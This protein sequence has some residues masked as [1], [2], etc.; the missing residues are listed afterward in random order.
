VGIQPFCLNTTSLQDPS[1][2][3]PLAPLTPPSSLYRRN[4][5]N[6]FIDMTVP[7]N[8]LFQNESGEIILIP[9]TPAEVFGERVLRPLID[10]VYSLISRFFSGWSKSISP[11]A[12]ELL[13]TADT[14]S[15]N[16]RTS[17]P[18]KSDR[19]S[20]KSF[21]LPPTVPS[22]FSLSKARLTKIFLAADQLLARYLQILPAAS[23]QPLEEKAVPTQS[24]DEVITFLKNIKTCQDYVLEMPDAERIQFML[25]YELQKACREFAK[26]L[27]EMQF[28][29]DD[30]ARRYEKMKENVRDNCL[31]TLRAR[32]FFKKEKELF[33]SGQNSVFSHPEGTQKAIA[34]ETSRYIQYR[35]LV[36]MTFT[37]LDECKIIVPNEENLE[38]EPCFELCNPNSDRVFARLRKKLIQTFE[39]FSSQ[40]IQ[41]VDQMSTLIH[42]DSIKQLMDK[43]KQILIE[44]QKEG[45]MN[46]ERIMATEQSL[47]RDVFAILSST[48]TV[49]EDATDCDVPLLLPKSEPDISLGRISLIGLIFISAAAAACFHP[50]CFDKSPD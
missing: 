12:E 40:N 11:V 7:D 15:L 20:E 5:R 29:L 6:S 2:V 46:L 43:T 37:D 16:G 8:R 42:V 31:A 10:E 41:S 17:S 3:I 45:Y 33:E 44:L 25:H 38:E 36:A 34:A 48:C 26:Q 28:D 27:V 30:R 35:T 24:L 22:H 47:E 19:F 39:A 14:V 23:A 49:L 9:K 13:E 1:L 18:E 4:S 50:R 21:L 32:R